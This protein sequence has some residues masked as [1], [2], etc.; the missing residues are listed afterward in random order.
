MSLE[1]RRKSNAY[2]QSLG[3]VLVRLLRQESSTELGVVEQGVH[4]I[5]VPSADLLP[6]AIRRELARYYEVDKAAYEH[7]YFRV[8]HTNKIL[9][10]DTSCAWLSSN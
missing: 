10:S 1:R 9:S 3:D 8:L 5:Q 7:F 6:P 4:F 2:T